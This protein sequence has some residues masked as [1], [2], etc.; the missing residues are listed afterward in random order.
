M[1]TENHEELAARAADD[2]VFIAYDLL[3]HISSLAVVAI[4]GILALLQ[5]TDAPITSGAWVSVALIG[6]SGVF[7]L[8]VLNAFS[9]AHIVGKRQTKG[10]PV[11][12]AVLLQLV[13]AS[14]LLGIGIFVGLFMGA[15]G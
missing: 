6:A 3:K 9:A 4:G 13:V 10:Y 11:S 14:F 15:L 7:A 2:R 12:M 1:D 5:A 8:I